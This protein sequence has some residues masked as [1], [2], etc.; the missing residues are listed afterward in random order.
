MQV[1]GF[2]GRS[3]HSWLRL[4]GRPIRLRPGPRG[5]GPSDGWTLI[6]LL[7]VIS[8]IMIL[9][10]TSLVTYRNS[11]TLAKEAA[12]HSDLF[13]MRDAIDQYYADKGKY[14]DALQTLV[15]ENYLRAIPKDPFTNS[16][17]TWQ[18]V[19]A[20]PQPGSTTAEPGIYEVKSGFDGMGIDGS[21]FSDW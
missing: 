9:A 16:S 18:T 8:I 7:I 20:E 21:R 5:L 2:A 13:M 15:S 1:P 19:E 17:D 12:L 4:A 6:E 3:L 14:P 10:A 11:V